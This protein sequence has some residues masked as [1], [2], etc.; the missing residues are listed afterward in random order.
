MLFFCGCH[1]IFQFYQLDINQP[2]DQ[3]Q[4]R[5]VDNKLAEEALCKRMEQMKNILYGTPD[6]PEVD[7]DRAKKLS[8]LGFDSQGSAE[9]S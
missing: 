9:I 5:Q 1:W 8:S 6:N 2:T 7:D 4:N 3:V